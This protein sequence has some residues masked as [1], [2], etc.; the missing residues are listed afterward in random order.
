MS[1]KNLGRKIFLGHHHVDGHHIVWQLLDV[2]MTRNLMFI[3]Q[4]YTPS[5]FKP[6]PR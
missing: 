2:F 6:N 4:W 1:C 5:A 3:A